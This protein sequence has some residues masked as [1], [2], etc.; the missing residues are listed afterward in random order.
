MIKIEDYKG[1][2][3]F[4]DEDSDK[5][6]TTMELNNVVKEPKRASLKALRQEINTF[7][8]LNLEFKPFKI[9]ENYYG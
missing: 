8:K 7:V 6:I 4:Y 9:L 3:I 1:F 2:E 5:F